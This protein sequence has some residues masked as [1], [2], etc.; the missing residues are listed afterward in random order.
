MINEH[1][2]ALQTDTRPRTGYTTQICSLLSFCG[3]GTHMFHV[4]TLYTRCLP[5]LPLPLFAHASCWWWIICALAGIHVY[6]SMQTRIHCWHINWL[7]R[8]RDGTGC[9]K[10]VEHKF[11]CSSRSAFF[12]KDFPI[13]TF[14][15]RTLFVCRWKL[16]VYA[17]HEH[18]GPM[19]EIQVSEHYKIVIRFII[20]SKPNTLT[21]L[22]V[23]LPD[24]PDVVRHGSI[25]PA[26]EDGKF[27]RNEILRTDRSTAINKVIMRLDFELKRNSKDRE[28]A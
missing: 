7:W 26:Y 25:A 28:N 1:I 22:T 3:M 19:Y 2:N 15:W 5:A 23:I 17:S 21:L 20:I 11:W 9:D 13:D 14:L 10:W 6:V 27:R 24:S 12:D 18:R 4:H 8:S 16:S